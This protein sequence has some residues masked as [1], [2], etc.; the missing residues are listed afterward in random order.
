[1][2]TSPGAS[3]IGFVNWS[4]PPGSQMCGHDLFA[5]VVQSDAEV[6]HL[7]GRAPLVEREEAPFG[8]F[9][10]TDPSGLTRCAFIFGRRHVRQNGHQPSRSKVADQ[11]VRPLGELHIEA[12]AQDRRVNVDSKWFHLSPVAFRRVRLTPCGFSRGGP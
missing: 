4:D 8:R 2:K 12:T 1:M 7:P 10:L 5:E 11:S 3:K 6:V 9:S